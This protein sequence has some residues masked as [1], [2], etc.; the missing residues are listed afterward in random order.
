YATFSKTLLF[1]DSECKAHIAW[2]KR[3]LQSIR[4]IQIILVA[5]RPI[6]LSEQ[7]D[8]P[9][10]FDQYGTITRKLSIKQVPALV[11]QKPGKRVLTIREEKIDEN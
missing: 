3:K 2:L 5:G 11:F 10:Y 7:L 9:V 4:N 1:I 6:Q 8:M